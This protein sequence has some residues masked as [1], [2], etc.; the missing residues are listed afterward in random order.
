MKNITVHPSFTPTGAPASE[1]YEYGMCKIQQPS[2]GLMS[3][4]I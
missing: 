3:W 4:R 1:S 2:Q